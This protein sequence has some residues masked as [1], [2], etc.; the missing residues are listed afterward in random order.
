MTGGEALTPREARTSVP[1]SIA[2]IKRPL[3]HVRFV[4]P[5]PE[6]MRCS[7]LFRK[8]KIGHPPPRLRL[9]AAQLNPPEVRS[10]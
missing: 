6:P 5:K 9:Q 3:R 4:L 2:A 10:P 8:L 7:N 1:L